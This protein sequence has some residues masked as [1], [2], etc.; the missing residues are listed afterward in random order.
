GAGGA[1]RA[2]ARGRRVRG[3]AGAGPPTAGIVARAVPGLARYPAGPASRQ[4]VGRFQHPAGRRP[5][6][7]PQGGPRRVRAAGRRDRT[8]ARSG[9]EGK[10]DGATSR[11]Q[12]GTQA[13]RGGP[14]HGAC[15][16]MKNEMTMKKLTQ[17]DPET[18]SL[19]GVAE[20]IQR[21]KALFPELVTEGPNGA[22]VN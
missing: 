6:C 20:N 11:A 5:A 1:S 7:R 13:R 2:L 12:P 16:F 4:S 22:A 18:R 10:A 9:E 19:D 3:G 14:C 17:N 8:P 15:P 21:L